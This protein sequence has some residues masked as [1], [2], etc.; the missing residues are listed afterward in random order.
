MVVGDSVVATGQLMGRALCA[1]EALRRGQT[2]LLTLRRRLMLCE[3]LM[4]AD[5]CLM[6]MF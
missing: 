6:L 3:S 1:G 4:H 5:G 2:K